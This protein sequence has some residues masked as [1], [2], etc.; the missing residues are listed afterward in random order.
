MARITQQ[1]INNILYEAKNRNLHIGHAPTSGDYVHEHSHCVAVN[2]IPEFRGKILVI[3]VRYKYTGQ[4]L[5]DKSY[6]VYEYTPDAEFVKEYAEGDLPAKFF[7]PGN[8]KHLP[9]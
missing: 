6:V 3:A 8:I 1:Q 2:L 7:L 4:H 5:Q 9:V